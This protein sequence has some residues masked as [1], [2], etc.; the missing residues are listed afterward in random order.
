MDCAAD[1]LEVF[2]IA[3]ES[4][5]VPTSVADFQ[6]LLADLAVIQSDFE[7]AVTAAQ[8]ALELDRELLYKA[9]LD[10]WIQDID[11]GLQLWGE[12]VGLA[13][14]RGLF[15]PQT[16]RDYIQNDALDGCG[17]ECNPAFGGDDTSLQCTDC[18]AAVGCARSSSTSSIPSSPPT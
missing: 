14:S 5:N 9:Y 4:L 11:E 6:Q 18:E 16:K 8:Q 1:L 10:F 17:F 7:T 2:V 12:G 13:L 15:D 3:A